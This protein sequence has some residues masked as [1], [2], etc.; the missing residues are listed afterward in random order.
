MIFTI[1]LA[2]ACIVIVIL[3]IVKGCDVIDRVLAPIATVGVTIIIFLVCVMIPTEFIPSFDKNTIYEEMET[4]PLYAISDG[5]TSHRYFLGSG[6]HKDSLHY[7]YCYETENGYRIGKVE[8]DDSALVYT[9]EEPCL[10]VYKAVGFKNFWMYIFHIPS[11]SCYQFCI[12][13]GTI[14]NSFQIDMH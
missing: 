5:V 11:Q 8:A 12:P 14:A 1:L 9:E 4:I 10:K 13:E 2:I 7:F 3:E 6:T